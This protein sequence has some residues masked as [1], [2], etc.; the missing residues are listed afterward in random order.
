MKINGKINF[1]KKKTGNLLYYL[2]TL[3]C[4][5]PHRLNSVSVSKRQRKNIA[6]SKRIVSSSH[7]KFVANFKFLGTLI[8]VLSFYRCMFI[9][10]VR[11]WAKRI[12]QQIE[13]IWACEWTIDLWV[14]QLHRGRNEYSI[15]YCFSPQINKTLCVL[16]THPSRLVHKLSHDSPYYSARMSAVILIR[17]IR[18]RERDCPF[19]SQSLG[20]TNLPVS[21]ATF[22]SMPVCTNIS[23]IVGRVVVKNSLLFF[24]FRFIFFSTLISAGTYALPCCF[25]I[26]M[27]CGI[28]LHWKKPSFSCHFLILQIR[29][30]K[31][32]KNQISLDWF[33]RRPSKWIIFSVM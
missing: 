4:P 32:K 8:H 13:L 10:S 28:L 23:Q 22:L 3:N 26:L 16:E 17:N 25:R 2:S 7:S 20:V 30:Q 6:M 5:I 18:V 31:L 19:I 12:F 33:L 21:T 11:I 27:Q 1:T 29:F 14:H 24:N 15:S 9:M